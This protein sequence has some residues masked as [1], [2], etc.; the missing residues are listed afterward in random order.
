LDCP[1]D[2]KPPVLVQAIRM[3]NTNDSEAE[4]LNEIHQLTT[5]REIQKKTY[6]IEYLVERVGQNLV[7]S[8]C[9]SL[10]IGLINIFV[11]AEKVISHVLGKTSP[12]VLLSLR[13]RK[14]L[15]IARTFVPSGLCL[16]DRVGLE[17]VLLLAKY[18]VIH[19]A[20]YFLPEDSTL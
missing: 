1:E 20:F 14:Y 9:R 3:Q 6:P 19:G 7:N 17:N 8:Q 12:F 16:R 5:T 15:D 11:C 10:K 18:I 4:H 2:L 13:I